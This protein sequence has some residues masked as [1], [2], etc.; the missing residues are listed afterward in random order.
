MGHPYLS[1]MEKRH[2]NHPGEM[3]TDATLAEREREPDEINARA[4]A[5]GLLHEA[6]VPFVVGGAYAYAT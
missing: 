6:G 2:P 5:V 3:G 1:P 4:R